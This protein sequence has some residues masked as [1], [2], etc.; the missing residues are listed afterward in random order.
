METTLN[1]LG[2]LSSTSCA[3]PYIPFGGPLKVGLLQVLQ[4]SWS[5]AI[6]INTWGLGVWLGD[7]VSLGFPE[8]FYQPPCFDARPQQS[9]PLSPQSVLRYL[10]WILGFLSAI[11]QAFKG[12]GE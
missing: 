8:I 4:L 11:S 2:L 9:V 1:L 6:S 3:V 7:L 5:R 10:V 12:R